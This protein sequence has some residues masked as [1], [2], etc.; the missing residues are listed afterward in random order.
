ME[1]PLD[2]L[3]TTSIPH[4]R[5]G[6]S[7]YSK[8]NRDKG[9]IFAHQHTKTEP[10]PMSNSFLSP[11]SNRPSENPTSSQGAVV[12]SSMLKNLGVICFL[13]GSGL[14]ILSSF[15]FFDYTN[16]AQSAQSK[17]SAIQSG[18]QVGDY[19]T[20]TGTFVRIYTL[21]DVQKEYKQQTRMITI[22]LGQVLMSL[23]V[24]FGAR[25]MWLRKRSG[26]F[27]IT[28]GLIVFVFLHGMGAYPF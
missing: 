8:I 25:S 5:C 20:A 27:L 11:E 2:S 14:L 13:L 28:F 6:E 4:H 3:S 22:S 18:G 12:N 15:T 16:K 1:R 9:A 17:I 26:I 24:L 10:Q 21:D 23:L 19:S 7:D